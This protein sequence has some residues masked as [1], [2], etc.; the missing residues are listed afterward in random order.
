MALEQGT[1]RIAFGVGEIV[2]AT[3]PTPVRFDPHTFSNIANGAAVLFRRSASDS[4][5]AVEVVAADAL[6]R[7]LAQAAPDDGLGSAQ[8]EAMSPEA[9]RL[10]VEVQFAP[11]RALAKRHLGFA[12]VR[13]RE[14]AVEL[15]AASDDD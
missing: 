11:T 1:A 3:A 13:M 14:F 5:W 2:T 9:V 6:N 15:P 10:L 7:L 8:I 12:R 4:R